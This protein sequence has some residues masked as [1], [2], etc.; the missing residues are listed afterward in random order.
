MGES[1]VKSHMKSKKHCEISQIRKRSRDFFNKE[2]SDKTIATTSTCTMNRNDE[3]K[4]KTLDTCVV[5]NDVLDAEILWT[6]KT[7]RNHASYKS[8]ENIEKIFKR[9]F[10]DS[11]IASK[12][13]CGERKTAYYAVFGIAPYLKNCLLENIAQNNFVLL[14]DESLNKMQQKKTNGCSCKIMAQQ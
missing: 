3:P 11:A 5:K 6:L 4:S 2:V 12:F 9:M 7:V 1:A 14:F 8:N 13:T 10:P